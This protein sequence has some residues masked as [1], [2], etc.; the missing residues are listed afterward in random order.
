MGCH[1]SQWRTHIFQRVFFVSTTNQWLLYVVHL[2]IFQPGKFSDSIFARAPPTVDSC[3][4][5]PRVKND[6][7]GTFCCGCRGKETFSSVDTSWYIMIHHDTSLLAASFLPFVSICVV[8]SMLKKYNSHSMTIFRWLN[9]VKSHG[10]HR[11]SGE[12]APPKSSIEPWKDTCASC[13]RAHAGSSGACAQRGGCCCVKRREVSKI[14]K[15][16]SQR[17]K[18]RHFTKIP[19]Q[20]SM[21]SDL[22][23][24]NPSLNSEFSRCLWGCIHFN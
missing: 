5:P 4:G 6:A 16:M 22:W 21:I 23:Y 24:S 11:Q 14:W 8:F 20:T 9:H 18:I 15:M 13:A 7:P 12:L 1:P 3:V 2:R 10:N 19:V 17:W